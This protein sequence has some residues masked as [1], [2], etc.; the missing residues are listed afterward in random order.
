[1]KVTYNDNALTLPEGTTVEDARNA[2]KAIYPE[3]ANAEAVEVDGGIEF[4]VQAGK[5][6]SEGL[7]VV[8]GDNA[9]NL[10]AGT[11]TEDAREA[12]KAIYPEIANASAERDGD[13]L[14]FTVQAGKKGR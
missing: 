12:L 13:T 6:G 7:K 3:I 9:L 8:Y 11:T 14:T 5:K 4:K 10:P 2:L 1:M